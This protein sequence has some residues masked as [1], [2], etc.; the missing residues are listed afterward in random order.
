M[1]VRRCASVYFEPREQVQLDLSQLLAGTNGMVRTVSWYALAPHLETPVPVSEQQMLLL[2]RL[3]SLQWQP[4]EPA[5]VEALADLVRL[6]LVIDSRAQDCAFAC[7]D[8]EV[9]KDNWWPLAA[10]LHRQGRWQSVDS[11]EALESAGLVTLEGLRD[12]LGAPPPSGPSGDCRVLPL[13]VPARTPFDALLA[14]RATCRNFDTGRGLELELL[15]QML[16]RVFGVAGVLEARGDTEFAKKGSP[17]AGGLHPTEAYLMVR[18]V[19][20][21]AEGLYHY[22]PRG[23]ALVPLPSLGEALDSLAMRW[24]SGQHWFAD[25]PVLVVMAP[26]FR[27]TFWKYRNHSK[28]Y[29]AVVLDVGHLSQTLYLAATDLGLGAFVT[30]AINERDIERSLALTALGDGPLAVAGFGWRRD[31][32]EVAEFDPGGE[33]WDMQPSAS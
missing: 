9:R 24:L 23:H 21:I 6:G 7:A 26:R 1:E 27:R 2:G 10:L 12:R 25:A 20:G 19:E 31:M 18:R 16:K 8:A 13:P 17:S 33:I 3:S 14:C 22:Q 5:S 32:L 28:A 4:V 29:R 30:A 15:S 11:V